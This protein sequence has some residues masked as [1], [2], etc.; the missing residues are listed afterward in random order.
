MRRPFSSTR[1]LE[2][3]RPRRFALELPVVVAIRGAELDADVSRRGL[4]APVPLADIV[5]ISSSTL[6]MPRRSMSLRVMICTGNRAFVLH[7][8]LML[9]PVISMRSPFCTSLL[10]EGGAGDE[11]ERKG[12]GPAWRVSPG[13]LPD[14]V[15]FYA[16]CVPRRMRVCPTDSAQLSC[17]IT[18]WLHFQHPGTPH[19]VASN[20]RRRAASCSV[21]P[22]PPGPSSP[23]SVTARLA[24]AGIPEDGPGRRG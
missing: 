14:L 13:C 19:H 7:A 2:A 11:D 10:R 9:L 23:D 1:V 21:R 3:P 24:A 6:V 20:P 18:N 17:K 15:W 12:P 22:C 16:A 8:R 4:S 5:I